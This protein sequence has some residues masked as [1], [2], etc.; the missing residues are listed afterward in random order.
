MLQVEAGLRE[1]N[2]GI[3]EGRKPDPQQRADFERMIRDW[4]AGQLDARIEGGETPREAWQR[5]EAFFEDLPH[6]FPGGR[7]LL[8]SHGRQLR[9]LLSQLVDGDLRFMHKYA[10]H[11]TGLSVLRRNASGRWEALTVNNIQ[12]LEPAAQG[13]VAWTGSHSS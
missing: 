5:A 4:D 6:R 3:M 2:W 9:I 13:Q 12:H 7:L 1:F 8:C 11:N 10:H